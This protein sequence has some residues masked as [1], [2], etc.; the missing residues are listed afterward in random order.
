MKYLDLGAKIGILPSLLVFCIGA[1]MLLSLTIL[2]IGVIAVAV[3]TIMQIVAY[4][5]D[6]WRKVKVKK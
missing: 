1:F 5:P 6:W 3:C 4:T 2:R